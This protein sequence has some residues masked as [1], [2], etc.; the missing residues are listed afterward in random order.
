M[1]QL[2]V[3]FSITWDTEPPWFPFWLHEKFLIP[4]NCSISQ[5]LGVHFSPIVC[6]IALILPSQVYLRDLGALSP[7]CCFSSSYDALVIW[8]FVSIGLS[9]FF[10]LVNTMCIIASCCS[11]GASSDMFSTTALTYISR[12]WFIGISILYSYWILISIVIFSSIGNDVDQKVIA[13]VLLGFCIIVTNLNCLAQLPG[14]SRYVPI[15]SSLVS[16]DRPN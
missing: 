15:L 10:F 13:S 4:M 5:I 9:L 1:I 6:G 3:S 7:S 12:Y 8:M 14:M 11:W 2:Y 16:K